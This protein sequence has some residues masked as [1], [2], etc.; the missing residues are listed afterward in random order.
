MFEA[1]L[2]PKTEKEIKNHL[3]S[4]RDIRIKLT[5][6]IG[7]DDFQEFIKDKNVD[8]ESC[9]TQYEVVVVEPNGDESLYTYQCTDTAQIFVA[10][11]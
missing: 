8:L 10:Y 5:E 4:L 9:P 11:Y 1:P 7:H 6:L 3:P 2:S